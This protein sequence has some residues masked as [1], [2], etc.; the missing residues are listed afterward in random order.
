MPNGDRHVEITWL[1]GSY[2]HALAL[3]KLNVIWHSKFIVTKEM[4][5][6]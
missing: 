1:T 5:Y 6:L 3:S 2:D 4:R